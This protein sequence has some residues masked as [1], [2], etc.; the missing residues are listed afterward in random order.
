MVM[1]QIAQQNLFG[2]GQTLSLQ[3]TLGTE[4]SLIDLSFMEPYLF[5]TPLYLKSDIWKATRTYDT[6]NLDSKGFGLTFGYPIWE[7]IMGYVG[8]RLSLNTWTTSCPRPPSRSRTR[9]GIPPQAA[10]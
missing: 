3:R 5:D 10:S 6:Y 2:R 4:S 8:Y 9:R 7:R 1:A